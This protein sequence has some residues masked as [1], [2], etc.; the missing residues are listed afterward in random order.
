MRLGIP[1]KV[2]DAS[3]SVKARESGHWAR[4]AIAPGSSLAPENQAPEISSASFPAAL[5]PT[6]DLVEMKKAELAKFDRIERHLLGVMTREHVRVD[7]RS[8][9]HG[10]LRRPPWYSSRDRSSPR[11]GTT[12]EALQAGRTSQMVASETSPRT[13]GG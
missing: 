4:R 2:A 10:R 13:G 11:L 9:R 7:Q 12:R 1:I 3:F 6:E 8:R 5:I